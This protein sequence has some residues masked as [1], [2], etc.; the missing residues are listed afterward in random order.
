VMQNNDIAP[1]IPCVGARVNMSP[2][3]DLFRIDDSVPLRQ[4]TLQ[5]VTLMFTRH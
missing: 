5:S 2:E 3:C 4:K 1:K